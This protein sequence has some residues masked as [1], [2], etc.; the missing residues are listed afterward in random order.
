MKPQILS[1][2]NPEGVPHAYLI[3]ASS[4]ISLYEDGIERL[5]YDAAI[6]LRHC[7]AGE[8]AIATP[9]EKG[10]S[11]I[12]APWP[13]VLCIRRP[14]KMNHKKAGV[15]L[16]ARN[17]ELRAAVVLLRLAK[18]IQNVQVPRNGS[19]KWSFGKPIQRTNDPDI[20]AGATVEKI[21]AAWKWSHWQR[22]SMTGAQQHADM[23][24]VG[25]RGDIG[26]F[27]EMM[28]S[29]GLSVTKSR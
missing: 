29:I 9:D 21:I 27:Y 2:H 17:L 6:D 15:G 22:N 14:D 18:S 24:A 4:A 5:S 1:V 3:D 28:A 26:A 25:F 19:K 20:L 23:K 11:R 12:I 7:K 8:I 10:K 13:A 16:E